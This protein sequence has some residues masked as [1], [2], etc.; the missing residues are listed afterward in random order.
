MEVQPSGT[1]SIRSILRDKNTPGTGR[2]VR[3]FSRDAYHVISPDVSE[4]D[5]V[6]NIP[7][8][9]N[10]ENPL[11]KPEQGPNSS[12]MGGSST[13]YHSAFVSP[14]NNV[15]DIFSL[16]DTKHDT[17]RR[18]TGSGTPCAATSTPSSMTGPARTI[19]S[20][21]GMVFFTP[22][23]SDTAFFTPEPSALN[24]P[25]RRTVIPVPE[26]IEAYSHEELLCCVREQLSLQQ[27]L[28]SQFEIDL[29][30]RDELVSILSTKLQTSETT[31][32]KYRKEIEKRQISMRAL[33]HKVADLEKLCQGL[34]EE[35]ERSREESFERSVMDE[36]SEGA[37][38][39]LHGSIGQLKS[40]LQKAKEESLALR[41]ERDS[42]R[43]D[44]VSLQA[45][46]QESKQTLNEEHGRWTLAEESKKNLEAQLLSQNAKHDATSAVIEAI[47]RTIYEKEGEIKML[48]E[49]LEA[50]WQNT[51]KADEKIKSLQ[52]EK[53]GLAKSVQ[54]LEA[55][56]E[57]LGAQW[58]DTDARRAE[59]EEELNEARITIEEIEHERDQVRNLMHFS[60]EYL[61]HFMQLA[62]DVNFE[63]EHAEQLLQS[64]AACENKVQELEQEQQYAADNIA[65]LE[66]LLRNR[67]SEIAVNQTQIVQREQEAE[68]LRAQISK[69]NREHNRL[70]EEQTHN[71][72][73]RTQQEEVV[74]LQLQTAVK[75]K[76]E[77]DVK[78]ASIQE[79]LSFLNNDVER[80][81]RQVHDLQ[82]ESADKE[83]KI[84]QLMKAR[85]QD[86]EDK[87]GLNIA[88]D[89][90][91]QELEL[92][93]FVNS[94]LFV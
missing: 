35:V 21:E 87:E 22:D 64:L 42:V 78:I 77:G 2:S 62:D 47:Q 12:Q 15:E 24:S 71:Q 72:N 8:N 74:R 55:R 32:E 5:T 50:Q 53:E 73:E 20:P 83:V 3:F 68:G 29:S 84:V 36:A 46:L 76:A 10:F 34:E 67:D 88:L 80:L 13:M 69:I 48:R 52:G 18:N 65:R 9:L 28:A 41:Q 85:T 70:V 4:M 49:E 19:L 23:A 59:L 94:P 75:Q 81:R 14:Q 17:I 63:R 89:S 91:Q 93:S 30:A 58:K 11:E 56:V 33:R 82:Q 26:D 92:V 25:S 39:V 16:P 60:G 37:L 40:E 27:L 90:K 6:E 7:P 38:V 86:K 44:N 1:G 54:A 45:Q 57:E 79:Q 43:E 31:V 66:E 61:M 51:E